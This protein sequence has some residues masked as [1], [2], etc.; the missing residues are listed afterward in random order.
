MSLLFHRRTQRLVGWAIRLGLLSIALSFALWL[1]LAFVGCSKPSPTPAA[2]AKVLTVL[3]VTAAVPMAF[4]GDSAFA[5][6]NSA[7]LPTFYESFRAEL[8]RQSV[9][10]WDGR[11]DC[12]HFAGYYV[13][14]AQTRYYLAS[15]HSSTPAQTLALGVYWYRRGGNGEGH[16]IVV[17][18]TERGTVFIEPQTGAEVRLTQAERDSAWLKVF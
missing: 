5:Q 13:A 3:D 17:A 4:V 9:T 14:L 12:N 18:L 16:A 6:V 2:T 8:F 15:F 7:W 10:R 11:F 1:T